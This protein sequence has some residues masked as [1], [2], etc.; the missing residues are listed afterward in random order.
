MTWSFLPPAD[1]AVERV[2]LQHQPCEVVRGRRSARQ[3]EPRQQ[4]LV[5]GQ[6]RCGRSCRAAPT[7]RTVREN[8]TWP[9][10]KDDPL[11]GGLAALPDDVA[12]LTPAAASID[13]LRPH[14][15]NGEQAM[16]VPQLCEAGDETVQRAVFL[17][18]VVGS[19]VRSSSHRVAVGTP[20]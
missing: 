19:K 3:L 9:T 7:S 4:W 8:E 11:P 12:V 1:R 18:G 13:D 14:S 20:A 5:N 2:P 16:L 6:R 17:F 15:P 10:W